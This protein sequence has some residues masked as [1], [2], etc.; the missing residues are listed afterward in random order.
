MWRPTART[1]FI[2]LAV[3]ACCAS[4]L[5]TRT[6]GGATGADAQQYDRQGFDRNGYD[7]DG[8][9]R[10]GFD[11]GG[12]DREGYSR[13]GFDIRGFDRLG[14][15]AAGFTGPAR[16]SLDADL[17][18]RIQRRALQCLVVRVISRPKYSGG[19][20]QAVLCAIE[21]VL[22]GSTSR[23]EMWLYFPIRKDLTWEVLDQG[24]RPATL[25]PGARLIVLVRA[26]RHTAFDAALR[27][28]ARS[29]FPV[30]FRKTLVDGAE[31]RIDEQAPSIEVWTPERE[32]ALREFL[33]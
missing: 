17:V 9:D 29:W 27:E 20:F 24:Y 16:L 4:V 10:D 33:R 8:Y 1:L 6:C 7:R 13:Q 3:A 12:F 15:P 25:H 19:P 5:V 32:R 26:V 18:H 28:E 22:R 30:P 11:R 23:R 31:M 2:S 14:N 21:S